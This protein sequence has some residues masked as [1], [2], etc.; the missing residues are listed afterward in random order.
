LDQKLPKHEK[1]RFRRNEISELATFPSARHHGHLMRR[2]GG[3]GMLRGLAAAATLLTSVVVVAAIVAYVIAT[4]DV[5]TEKLGDEAEAAIKSFSGLDVDATFGPAHISL[6]RS[7]LLAVSVPAVRL[8]SRQD[9]TPIIEAGTIDFGV[10]AVPLLSGNVQLGSARISDAKINAGALGTDQSSDWTAAVRNADGLIDPDLI[11][12]ALFGAVHRL[13]DALSVGSTRS[14]ELDNVDVVLP[15]AAPFGDLR[16]DDA[17]LSQIGEA[18]M[19]FSA[20]VDVDGRAIAIDGSATLDPK[21]K[22]VTALKVEVNADGPAEVAVAADQ[23]AGPDG[24]AGA[25]PA[26]DRLGSFDVSLEG[27]EGGGDTPSR[28]GLSGTLDSSIFAIDRKNNYLEGEVYLDASIVTGENKVRIKKLTIRQDRSEYVLYGPLGPRPVKPGE[29]PAY[30]FELA[31]DSSISAPAGSTEPAMQ[32]SAMLAGTFDPAASRLDVPSIRLRTNSGEILAQAAVDFVPG[33][34]PGIDIAA[35]VPELSMSHLKQF[36][37]FTA[38]GKARLW[39]MTNLFGG[40]ITNGQVRY[41]VPPGRIGNGVPLSADEVFGH[42]D[43]S[44]ARFDIAGAL[45]PMRD[46]AAAIDFRGNDVDVA[47]SSGAVYLPDG[48]SVTASNGIFTVRDAYRLP[49]IGQLGLDIAG[50]ASSIAELASY[51]P[52]DGLARTGMTPDEFSGTMSG[53][54]DAQIPLAGDVDVNGLSWQVSLDYKD[55]GLAKP[56]EDQLLTEANGSIAIDPDKAVIKA[57]GRLNGAP[58]EIAMVEPLRESGPKPSRDVSILLD[59]DARE[60]LAPG[61]GT[62]VQG[63]IKLSMTSDKG[64]GSRQIKVDLTDARLDLPW[65]GWSKG[66]G[67]AAS[68]AFTLSRNDDRIK[69][70]DFKLS[71]KTFSISGDVVLRDGALTSARLGSVQLNRGDDVSVSIERQGKGFD[72][73]VTGE[74]LDMRSMIKLLKDETKAG[75]GLSAGRPI[76]VTAKVGRLTGFHDEVLSGVTLSY[77]SAGSAASDASFSGTT[78]S[79]APVSMQ[80]GTEDGE[81]SLQMQSKDAGAVLRFLDIYEHMVGGRIQFDLSG[82]SNGVLTGEIDASNFDIVD[83]PK[84][85]SLV[86]TAPAGDSRSLN[87]AI[88]REIDTSRVTFERGYAMIAKGDGALE[89][90]KGVLRG[91][92]IGSTFQGTLYDKAGN[93]N[94]T[95]TFMPAYGI[96]RIFG[97]LPLVGL[98]L[99]N[100]NDRGLIGVTFKLTGAADKPT[101]QINPLSVIAPGIFRSIFEFR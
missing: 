30:R 52:I 26:T 88:K 82:P 91:P 76:S 97:E 24:D 14:I 29:P 40:R 66:T 93:M 54:V 43:I 84:L 48:R 25:P 47:L 75:D 56:V 3:R 10:R 4:S 79:G 51:E 72:I 6:D 64:D 38:A 50:D 73:D 28:L 83:E 57:K 39:A 71:G 27:A 95:G 58:A 22:S 81:R 32:F 87:Q 89:L 55:L 45:P 12:P 1:I 44:G 5:T 65:I 96:N 74:A 7:H 90:K 94:M 8:K 34:A 31:S 60:D 35:T 69:L 92:V 49:V 2:G 33:K 86:S 42:L 23:Q 101:L 16:I 62:L 36:W 20:D 37:P 80:D 18:E 9:G 17:V 19:R 15:Q 41:R 78:S 77:K 98:I 61:L 100:G 85:R 99:G 11:A 13:Y 67:V 53:H 63:P 46:A 59:D 70:D 68:A 21:S